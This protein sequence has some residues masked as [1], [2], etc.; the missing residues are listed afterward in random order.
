MPPVHVRP[1]QRLRREGKNTVYK[2]IV[3]ARQKKVRLANQPIICV[4]FRVPENLG[5]MFYIVPN[6]IAHK[7]NESRN[8]VL[9]TSTYIA[10][11][12]CSSTGTRPGNKK[13]QIRVTRLNCH[14]CWCLVGTN[15]TPHTIDYTYI[16]ISN[17]EK[18]AV[19][20]QSVVV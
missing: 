1:L 14:L 11:T 9:R 18:N 3:D 8:Y 17:H 10:S 16:N 2:K 12:A 20:G 6:K 5:S 19:Y 13:R 7:V 15:K 4:M